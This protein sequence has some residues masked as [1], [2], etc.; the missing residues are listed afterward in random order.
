MQA[1]FEGGMSVWG[2][3]QPQREEK[4][5]E[6]LGESRN[7]TVRLLVYLSDNQRFNTLTHIPCSYPKLILTILTMTTLTARHF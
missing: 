7:D 5:E 4:V 1:Y 3:I 6:R 2:V